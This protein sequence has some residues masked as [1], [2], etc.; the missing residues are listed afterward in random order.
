MK[1]E[2]KIVKTADIK[3]LIELYKDAGWWKEENDGTDPSFI[4]K[5]IEGS[6][7]FAIAV[8]E[9]KIIGM[10]RSISDGVSDAYIQDVAVLR[11]FRG[12]RIGVKIMDEI[13]KFLKNKNI[14]WI[15]L[16]AEPNAVSFYDRYGFSRM[17][18]YVPFLLKDK[19]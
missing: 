5:I 7:C 9:D 4:Q 14:T 13:I 12:Q 11:E 3:Q 10:G 18:N 1:I 15:G 17:E 8:I 2:I 16:I 6:F 19:L